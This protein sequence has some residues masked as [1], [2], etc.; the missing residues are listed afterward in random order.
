M[1]VHQNHA[2]N[3]NKL[4]TQLYPTD[5]TYTPTTSVI[6]NIEAPPLT[7]GHRECHHN[8]QHVP[9]HPQERQK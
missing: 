3:I 6:P 4:A 2:M 8:L 7:Y 1:Y 9:G 5:P